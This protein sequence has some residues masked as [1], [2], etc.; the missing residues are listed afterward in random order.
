MQNHPMIEER[1]LSLH[2]WFRVQGPKPYE[3]YELY[4]RRQ[5]LLVVSLICYAVAKL[6][7]LVRSSRLVKSVR[8]KHEEL[9]QQR[10]A[11]ERRMQELVEGQRSYAQ[12]EQHSEVWGPADPDNLM[13][14]K[15]R[16]YWMER[17]R[18]FP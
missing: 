3:E 1:L 6:R 12:Y 5:P 16:R 18:N 2:P 7:T 14:R 11:A 9:L 10:V 15:Y 8:L 13:V 4:T 17:P